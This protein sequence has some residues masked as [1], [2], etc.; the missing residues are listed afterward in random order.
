MMEQ[1]KIISCQPN[2][3]YTLNIFEGIAL[4]I[5]NYLQEHNQEESI[6]KPCR[7]YSSMHRPEL[8]SVDF[9]TTK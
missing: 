9:K 3:Q 7:F 5:Q 4:Y 2:G 1:F 6:F 8:Y